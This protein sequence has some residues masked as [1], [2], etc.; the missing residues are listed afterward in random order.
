MLLMELLLLDM[1]DNE[2]QKPH[3]GIDNSDRFMMYPSTSNP[4]MHIRYMFHVLKSKNLLVLS[5]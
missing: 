5:N 2:E 4:S 1:V 3:A